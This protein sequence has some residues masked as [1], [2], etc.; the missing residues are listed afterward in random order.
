MVMSSLRLR[1][2]P[3]SGHITA[4][5]ISGMMMIGV[6]LASRDVNLIFDPVGSEN[7]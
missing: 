6:S 2:L 4:L 7:T 5:D 3:D 1:D